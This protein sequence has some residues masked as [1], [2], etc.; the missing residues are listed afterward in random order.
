MTNK[1]TYSLFTD[2]GA[3]GNPGPAGLGFSLMQDQSEVLSG[4]R[5]IGEATNNEAEY[6]ALILALSNIIKNQLDISQLDCY[7]DSQLVVMQVLGKYKVKMPHLQQLY[8]QVQKLVQ[9]FQAKGCKVS[10]NHIPR[11]QNKRADQLVN[12]AIDAGLSLH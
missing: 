9:E 12:I 10:F 6:K 2:G 8:L 5:Y 7:L 11:N 4:N 3:R 1:Q